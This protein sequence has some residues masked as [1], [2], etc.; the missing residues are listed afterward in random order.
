MGWSYTHLALFGPNQWQVAAE[1][2]NREA[3]ISPT[4]NGFT[5]VADQSFESHERGQIANLA[6]ELSKKLRCPAITVFVFDDDVLCYQLIEAGQ[7]LD[8]YNS[9]PDYFDLA[10][11]H[12]HPRSPQGGDAGRLCAALRCQEACQQGK[13]PVRTVWTAVASH[14]RTL[15]VSTCVLVDTY[16]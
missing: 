7:I 8:E 4:V 3:A 14:E 2:T 15:K 9:A 6:V 16:E 1:L 12:V 13:H 10:A 11:K 5:L